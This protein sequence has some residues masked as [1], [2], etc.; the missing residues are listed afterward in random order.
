MISRLVM[1]LALA[2]FTALPA[3]AGGGKITWT[4]A[5][6]GM[7]EARKTGRPIFM[8]FTADW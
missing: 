1:P 7:A 4:D 5:T 6:T 2:A 8:Y 3:V